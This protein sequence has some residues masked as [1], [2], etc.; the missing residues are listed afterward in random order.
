MNYHDTLFLFV[1]VT[2]LI[3]AALDFVPCSSYGGISSSQ[4][5]LMKRVPQNVDDRGKVRLVGNHSSSY[6]RDFSASPAVLKY[7]NI[8]GRLAHLESAW[9]NSCCLECFFKKNCPIRQKLA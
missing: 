8:T 9:I 3:D 6:I 1:N 2:D 4:Q 5:A 7:E